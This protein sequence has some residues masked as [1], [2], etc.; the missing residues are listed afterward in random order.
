VRE[1]LSVKWG[2]GVLLSLCSSH[3]SLQPSFAPAVLR[4][5]LGL[6]SSVSANAKLSTTPTVHPHMQIVPAYMRE[7]TYEPR[8]KRPKRML[9]ANW[10]ASREAKRAAGAKAKAAKLARE[11]KTNKAVPKIH[12]LL[13]ELGSP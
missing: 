9:D 11:A 5:S 8:I 6:T 12:I 3:S 7:E 10:V 13:F 1:G 2:G 4:S